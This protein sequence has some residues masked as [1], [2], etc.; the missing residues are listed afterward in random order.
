VAKSLGKRAVLVVEGAEIRVNQDAIQ[1]LI[2]AIPHL[3]RNALDHGIETMAERLEAKKQDVATLYISIE[4]LGHQKLR[5]SFSDDGRGI[6]PDKIAAAAIRKGLLSAAAADKLSDVEKSN[7]ILL[8]GFTSATEITDITGRGIG[9]SAVKEL[10]ENKLSGKFSLESQP[11]LG[12]K[13]TLDIPVEAIEMP[14]IPGKPRLNAA[15]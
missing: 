15:S 7:L 1:P 14:G 6:Y 10:I 5:I 2:D 11:G 4:K 8:P 3:I 12:T 9:L 13:I